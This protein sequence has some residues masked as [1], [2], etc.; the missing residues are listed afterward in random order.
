MYNSARHTH[1]HTHRHIHTDTHMHTHTHT[2]THRDIQSIDIL[3]SSDLY[4][5]DV[6]SNGLRLWE[7]AIRARL[8]DYTR[9]LLSYREER[10]G[11]TG[12]ED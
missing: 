1:T 5:S 10:E 3:Q 12:M 7:V 4:G 11:G 9:L 6:Q 2:D 8:E